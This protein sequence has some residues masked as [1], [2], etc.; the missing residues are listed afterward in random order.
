MTER[1]ASVAAVPSV[2]AAAFVLQRKCSCGRHTSGGETCSECGKKK[3][4]LQRRAESGSSFDGP[5]PDSVM[6]VLRS[7]G[8]PLD[9]VV[10]QYMEP[11]FGHDFSGVRVHSDSSAANSARAVGAF[12]YT[13]GQH[14]V[15]AEGQHAPHSAVGQHLLA[16]ELTHS[17][18][19]RTSPISLNPRLVVGAVDTAA[20]IEADRVADRVVAGDVAPAVHVAPAPVLQ[21]APGPTLVD[22]PVGT[23]SDDAKAEPDFTSPQ[24]RGGQGRAATVDGGKRGDDEVKIHVVRYLCAC[25][26]HNELRPKASGHLKPNP[27]GT[28]ELCD[29]DVTVGVFGD[30]VPRTATKGTV[31]VGVDL[32]VANRVNVDVHGKAQNTGTEPQVGPGVE[33]R[34]KLPGG[35]QVGVG[36][37][38]LKGTQSGKWNIEGDVG[39]ETPGGT[40]IGVKVTDTPGGPYTIT[41]VVGGNLPGQNVSN[42]TCR[43]CKCPLFYQCYEDI[44]PRPYETP[45]SY[46]VEQRG[47]LRYYFSL[48][49]ADD[50]TD[51]QL[52]N[53][54]KQTLDLAAQQVA[55]G[56]QISSITGYASPEDNREK[57]EPN[58]KL[59]LARAQRLRDLLAKRLGS[60]VSL[61]APIAGGEL[62]G[63]VPAITPGSALADAML[64][65]GFGDAE[66]VTQF[67][68]GSDIP[69]TKLAD[70]FLGLLDR[71]TDPADRLKL[72]GV[73]ASSPA[74]PKLL[75][76]IEEFR[77]NR[78]RGRRPWEGIF[79]YLR[80]ATVEISS[81]H[82]EAGTEQ[83]TTEGSFTPMSDDACKPYARH[84]EG[85]DSF[86]PA[87]EKPAE[88]S[89]CP[90][91]E[92]ANQPKTASVCKYN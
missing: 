33:G 51:A 26:G 42:Q 2:P 73:D 76:A 65:V 84:A 16:H 49:K 71:V 4:A 30:I 90:L 37:D 50:T 70:Q 80:Y 91:G 43:S 61:P 17:I 29:G 46:D 45:T 74:A 62:L 55:A 66:D 9:P 83:H 78:G 44:P 58:Q 89:D 5:V 68:I 28:L 63:R 48:D 23:D 21:R 88:H 22:K 10:R 11:R 14:I 85:E 56:S 64:S 82:K 92:P 1:S 19:Q 24:Q 20:E 31:K 34:V 8:T 18:Q 13:V 47:R 81:K 86:G 53:E 7:T 15:F 69:N 77:K 36:G 75:A 38:A 57:P 27:G 12:A 59:S 67:L 39:Y 3:H 6:D 32:N 87:Q 52:K 25:A 54:S 40:K 41:P 79:G 35:G 60:G 72:F